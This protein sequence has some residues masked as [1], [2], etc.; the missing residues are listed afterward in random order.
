MTSPGP[1]STRRRRV[2]FS[3]IDDVLA[4]VEA[5]IDAQR[6]GR[7]RATGGWTPAQIC[8]HLAKFIEFSYDGFPFRA[9]LGVRVVSHV[10]KCVAWKR[11]VEWSLQPGYKLPARFQALAPDPKAEFT[12]SVVRLRLA[13][14]R[15][16]RG[17]PMLQPS[18]FEGR[19]THE[20]WVY[21]HL[22]HAELHLSYLEYEAKG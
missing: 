9:S 7:L 21:V 15:I 12:A 10:A 8:E 13:L 18:P 16:R 19:I 17:E 4:D 2:A 5:I 6:S 20:Q 14:D 11:F 22:R 1:R 3:S